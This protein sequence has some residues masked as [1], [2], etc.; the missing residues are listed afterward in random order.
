MTGRLNHDQDYTVLSGQ[1]SQ[2][3]WYISTR[4]SLFWF[5][6]PILSHFRMTGRLNPDQNNTVRSG[7]SSQYL[8]Y[9]STPLLTQVFTSHF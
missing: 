2:Y 6:P 8:W 5:L 1:L 9:I 7:L 4:F 3:L